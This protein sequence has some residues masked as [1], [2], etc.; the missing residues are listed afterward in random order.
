MNSHTKAMRCNK[1]ISDIPGNIRK[2]AVTRGMAKRDDK[3]PEYMAI[4]DKQFFAHYKYFI[5]IQ[6]SRKDMC[7]ML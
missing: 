6:I 1:D 4:D 5:T 7:M 3:I 2:R